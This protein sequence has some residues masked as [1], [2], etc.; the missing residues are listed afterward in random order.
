MSQDGY[1]L[2]QFEIPN[3]G[4]PLKSDLSTFWGMSNSSHYFLDV[5]YGWKLQGF[6]WFSFLMFYHPHV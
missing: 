1:Y 3:L 6:Q 2:K 5:F 4:G